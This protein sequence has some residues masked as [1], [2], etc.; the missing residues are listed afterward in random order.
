MALIGKHLNVFTDH[1]P[2]NFFRLFIIEIVVNQNRSN[3][4]LENVTQKFNLIYL[5][6]LKLLWMCNVLVK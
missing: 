5:N 3:Q 4:T 6:P 1:L 2:H